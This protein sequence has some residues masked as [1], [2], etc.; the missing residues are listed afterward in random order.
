MTVSLLR[1]C[2]VVGALAAVFTSGAWAQTDGDTLDKVRKAGTL[3]IGNG[4]AYPPFEFVENGK[5]TGFDI[6]LGNELGK[7]MGV[8]VEWKVTEFA[9]LLAALT[10]GR[11]DALVTAFTSTPERAAKIAFS[12]GYY[13]TGIAA[14]YQVKDPVRTPQELQGKV[15]GVQSGTPGDKFIR[16]GHADRVKEVR[17]YG[18]FHLAL[19]DLELGRTQVVINTLPVLRYNLARHNTEGKIS[20]TEAW[21]A[22]DLGINTRLNDKALMAEINKHLAAMRADGFLEQ[23]NTKWFG[24]LP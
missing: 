17:Q 3:V 20:V 5:L 8:K 16:E 7:R 9:G 12:D 23:L 19:R 14:A 1:R 15:V 4:G 11:V 22:R 2:A 13:K 21:D 24:K 10:S 6:D 18:E